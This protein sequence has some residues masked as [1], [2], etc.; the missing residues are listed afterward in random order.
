MKRILICAIL[1]LVTLSLSAQKYKV[2]DVEGT[3]VYY[4]KKEK[5][6]IKKGMVLD[7]N[8][9]VM[10]NYKS[11]LSLIEEKANGK[12]IKLTKTGKSTLHNMIKA[13]NKGLAKVGEEY[14]EYIHNQI[15]GGDKTKQV[16][17][18]PA[19]VT[20]ETDS[21]KVDTLKECPIASPQK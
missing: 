19:T 8:T 4:S 10:L 17:S 21:I 3:A 5:L 12:N 20:R 16:H 18:D 6:P 13:E 1:A 2:T 9:V 14:A 11:S 7:A 15:I